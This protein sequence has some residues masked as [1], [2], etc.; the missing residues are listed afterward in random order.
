V[1]PVGV[2]GGDVGAAVTDIILRKS[3]GESLETVKDNQEADNYLITWT[4]AFI[5]DF[6][7][8]GGEFD[9]FAGSNRGSEECT[10]HEGYADINVG[11]ATHGEI[12]I[13]AAMDVRGTHDD[14][15]EADRVVFFSN[16]VRESGQMLNFLNISIYGPPPYINAFAKLTIKIFEL[17]A[18][19][20]QANTELI[21]KLAEL[22]QSF[23]SPAQAVAL[24]VFTSLGQAF[25]TANTDDMEMKFELGFDPRSQDSAV[26]RN[27][28]Q[29]G[30]IALIRKEVRSDATHFVGLRICP[31]QGFIAKGDKCEGAEPW[32]DATWLLLRISTERSDVTQAQM[33]DTLM[34]DLLTSDY[35]SP[36]AT[37]ENR[38]KIYGHLAAALTAATGLKDATE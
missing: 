37:A 25:T 7:K 29:E 5:C 9:L 8:F 32:R 22:G 6:R 4:S 23:A 17:D 36:S 13:T 28:M 30:Y 21:G 31:A 2:S 33:L 16:D 27:E 38:T 18:A 3:L 20:S 34:S 15:I 26:L 12:A 14:A 11:V 1:A 10:S 24:K 19:E 35:L